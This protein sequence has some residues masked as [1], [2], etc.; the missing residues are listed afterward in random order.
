VRGQPV[1]GV[2][3]AFIGH[4]LEAVETHFFQGMRVMKKER[5][6]ERSEASRVQ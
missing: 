3:R 4:V 2:A 5:H 1:G 6:A